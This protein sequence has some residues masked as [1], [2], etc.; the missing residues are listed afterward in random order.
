MS[1]L[2]LENFSCWNSSLLPVL[3]PIFLK[4]LSTY[5]LQGI[6]N[7]IVKKQTKTHHETY[8]LFSVMTSV[9]TFYCSDIRFVIFFHAFYMGGSSVGGR[10]KMN[11]VPFTLGVFHLRPPETLSLS[12]YLPFHLCPTLTQLLCFLD[13]LPL[14]SSCDCMWKR[15][16]VLSADH[17]W[18]VLCAGDRHAGIWQPRTQQAIHHSSAWLWS[19]IQSRDFLF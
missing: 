11:N 13:S 1:V 15:R 3:L 16:T 10:I 5:Y 19:Y 18:A 8:C 4:Y 2:H 17:L 6:G 14:W 12:F 9:Q 7:I